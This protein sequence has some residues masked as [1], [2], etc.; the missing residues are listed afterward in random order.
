MT[1]Q[2]IVPVM[3]LVP[4]TKEPFGTHGHSDEVNNCPFF[5]SIHH[6]GTQILKVQEREDEEEFERQKNERI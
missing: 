5:R 6:L 2:T 4:R 3:V 1:V